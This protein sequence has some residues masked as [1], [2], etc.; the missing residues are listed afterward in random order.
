MG[1]NENI[2]KILDFIPAFERD[3]KK[4]GEL[5]SKL[6][7]SVLALD[8]ALS[9]CG[10][11]E[12]QNG[13]LESRMNDLEKL[14]HNNNKKASEMIG[15][16]KPYNDTEIKQ[17]IKSLTNQA[18]ERAES[19]GKA[20]N[21]LANGFASIKPFDDSGLSKRIDNIKPYD[22]SE[23][24]KAISS[25]KPYDD[26]ELRELI[27]RFNGL[28][29]S[30]RRTEGEQSAKAISNLGKDFEELKKSVESALKAKGA[31]G[32]KRKSKSSVRGK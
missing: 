4:V 1:W 20:I 31:G 14:N 28:F 17:A 12:Q 19:H 8:K 15:D 24:K 32:N 29:D 10:E 3:S 13:K 30:F 27:G 23:I 26:K 2:K 22:D 11:L 25:I 21:E 7:V 6:E 9:R 18:K 5:A 16:I